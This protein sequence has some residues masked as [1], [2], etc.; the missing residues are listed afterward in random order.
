MNLRVRD[1]LLKNS[2]H[3]MNAMGFLHP[4]GIDGLKPSNLKGILVVVTTAIGDA[5]LCTPVFKILKDSIPHVKIGA[6]L[7]H[8]SYKLFEDDPNIDD[9]IVYAGKYKKI[10]RTM[11][12]L[13]EGGY[14][15]A[16]VA[17][18]NDPDIIPLIYWSGIRCIIRRPQRD[19]VYRYLV[20]N[21][22]M[23]SPFHTE[24]HAIVRNVEMLGLIGIDC[25]PIKPYL[26][27][28]P[29]TDRR[30][31]EILKR[32]GYRRDCPLFGIHPGASVSTKMWPCERYMELVKRLHKDFGA[33]IIITGSKREKK[34]CKIIRERFSKDIVDLSGML[35]VK[36][37][38]S[39]IKKLDLFISG[40]TGPFHIAVAHNVKTVTL[41]GWSDEEL[42][43]PYF[44]KDIHRVVR[45]VYPPKDEWFTRK[46]INKD[47]SPLL[48]IEV[49]D[50]LKEVY[51]CVG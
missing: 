44:D 14:D 35:G 27:T 20:A 41:F 23:L 12:Q 8:S 31:T 21:P 49:D 1:F 30:T 9:I 11:K 28:D 10:V 18:A 13:K 46:D 36:E 34:T 2:M 29:E 39:L 26:Y 4:K 6:F 38:S 51:K 25:K 17:N 43:G 3:I 50:V 15:I 42:T 16:L 7:H 45:K 22:H 37:L 47:P 24:G 19:T 5:I 33:Y 40:D 32:E 48:A